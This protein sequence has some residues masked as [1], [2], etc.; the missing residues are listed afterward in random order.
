MNVNTSVKYLGLHLNS[1]VIVGACSL[2]QKPEMVRELAI[3]GAGAIVLPSLFEEQIV[4]QMLADGKTPSENESHLEAARY[5]EAEDAYNGGPS[6]YLETIKNLKRVTGIPVIANLN[7]CTEGR[8]LGFAKEIEL[9][10]AD[11]IELAL[12]SELADS[13]CGAD[14]V[15]RRLI[16]SVTEVCDLVNV[17]VS[18][19]LT[20]FHTN[21]ANL[22]W[23]LTEAGAAG[24]VC[25]A[26]EPAWQVETEHVGATINWALTP[27]SNIN[28]TIAGLIRV[29]A[30][31]P[32]ISVAASGGISVPQDLIKTIIAG[33]DVAMVTSEVYRTGPDA[34]AH[35]LDGLGSYLFRHG[36]T[37]F[38][39]FIASRPSPCRSIRGMQVGSLTGCQEFVDPT[40]AVNHRSGDRWGHIR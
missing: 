10:G 17:P 12:D 33:A 9:A 25:F 35:L 15:E 18:V 29:R 2:T 4:H 3:A 34:V 20:S 7:G 30:K 6:E 32:A 28:A 39:E 14:E 26:H 13:A 8:W 19:K 37:S 38:E 5:E 16:D 1:P 24:L 27:A 11:A 40:P 22:A 21:L 36:F 23:R 31:G